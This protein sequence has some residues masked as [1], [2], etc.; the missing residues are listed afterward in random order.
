MNELTHLKQV[1]DDQMMG[2]ENDGTANVPTVSRKKAA[3]A[4]MIIKAKMDW[5]QYI[6]KVRKVQKEKI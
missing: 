5:P 2:R 6:S 3:S 1:D 4:G